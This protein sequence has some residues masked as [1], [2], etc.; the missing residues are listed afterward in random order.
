[1]FVALF[2]LLTSISFN[3]WLKRAHPSRKDSATVHSDISKPTNVWLKLEQPLNRSRRFVGLAPLKLPTLL[4]NEIQSSNIPWI[5][6]SAANA[7][8]ET[9]WLKLEQPFNIPPRYATL[10]LTKPT[11][12]WLNDV[13]PSN[14]PL[15]LTVPPVNGKRHA[16]IGW[17]Y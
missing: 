10:V 7:T 8:P 5:C 16:A 9:G 2:K 12:D 15:T 14:I 11:I 17:L 13:A 3:G 6:A 1:M 4:L